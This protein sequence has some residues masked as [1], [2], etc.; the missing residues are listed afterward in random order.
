MVERAE[1]QLALQGELGRLQT[2][3]LERE[4]AEA[5]LVCWGGE[6]GGDDEGEVGVEEDAGLS[7]RV[8]GR[9][10]GK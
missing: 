9:R 8:G 6:D 3:S 4:L 2:D 10:E 7:L 1:A 5:K